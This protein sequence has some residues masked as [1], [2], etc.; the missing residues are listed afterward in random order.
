MQFGDRPRF[1]LGDPAEASGRVARPHGY[2]FRNCRGAGGC[3]TRHSASWVI[4]FSLA[5]QER[6]ARA[7]LSPPKANAALNRAFAR[8]RKLI[9]PG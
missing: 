7:L 1:P 5:D 8:Q 4:A 2:G 6:F 3:T 9:A